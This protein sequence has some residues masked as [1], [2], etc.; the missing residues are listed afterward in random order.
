MSKQFRGDD[1]LEDL[2]NLGP[3]SAAMLRCAGIVDR[4]DLERL[5]AVKSF[6]AVE[7][8]GQKPSRN[9]L[10]AIAGALQGKRWNKLSRAQKS[11]LVDELNRLRS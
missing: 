7:L 4:H 9:L 10:W 11:L 5:G 2:P 8:S 1:E 3:A 6:L